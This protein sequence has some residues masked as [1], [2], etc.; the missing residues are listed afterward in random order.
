MKMIK[1]QSTRNDQNKN[2]KKCQGRNAINQM[3]NNRISRCNA[4]PTS[5]GD[6]FF[7]F[8][9]LFFSYQLSLFFWRSMD[10]DDFVNLIGIRRQ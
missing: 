3:T 9:F 7:S 5:G 4:T 1:G 10:E 2:K 6:H 8:L